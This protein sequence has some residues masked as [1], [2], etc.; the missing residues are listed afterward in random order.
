MHNQIDRLKEG[1]ERACDN[2]GKIYEAIY[3]PYKSVNH[4]INCYENEH[5]AI[6]HKHRQK[7]S[8][9]HFF[10]KTTVTQKRTRI[11]ENSNYENKCPECNSEHYEKKGFR[12]QKQRYICKDCGRNWTSDGVVKK[13]VSRKPKTK[14]T[15]QRENTLEEIVAY[16]KNQEKNN[17]SLKFWYRDDT[18]PR[19]MHDYFIDE[20]YVQ[21]RADKEYYIKFLIDK[22]RKI[23][24]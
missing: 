7:I 17:E 10:T 13:F 23:E 11:D 5:G 9:K 2:C 8:R 16:L 19:E 6:L 1:D 20:K 18:S 22:I 4:C 15:F 3:F 12:N 14:D 24:E 21:V